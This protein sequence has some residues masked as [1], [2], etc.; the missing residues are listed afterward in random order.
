MNPK[1]IAL[2][3]Q[4]SAAVK[5]ILTERG[6][7]AEIDMPTEGSGDMHLHIGINGINLDMNAIFE[8]AAQRIGVR[9]EGIEEHGNNDRS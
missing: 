6:I 8:E 3:D 5:E 4:F 2:V 7:D 1:T 9:I